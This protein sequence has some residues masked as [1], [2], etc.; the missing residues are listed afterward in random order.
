MA[1]RRVAFFGQAYDATRPSAPMPDFL[2]RL[3]QRAAAWADVDAEAL[4]TAP[5]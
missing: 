3:R 1:R 5:T 4:V 2:R